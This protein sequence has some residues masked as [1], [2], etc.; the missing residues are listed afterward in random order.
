LVRPFPRI[1]N[2]LLRFIR[3]GIQ[4][5]PFKKNKRKVGF[6]SQYTWTRFKAEAIANIRLWLHSLASQRG[7]SICN[8]TDTDAIRPPASPYIMATRRLVG[9]PYQDKDPEKTPPPTADLALAAYSSRP[10]P[11]RALAMVRA[12]PPSFPLW[13][14]PNAGLID[15]LC[16]CSQTVK[17][18]NGGRSKHGRGQVKMVRCHNCAKAVPKVSSIIRPTFQIHFLVQ[19]CV[20]TVVGFLCWFR[21]RRSNATG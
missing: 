7:T 19:N 12:D 18:R 8:P 3:Y 2:V 9:K 10:R 13:M 21:T 16:R 15:P 17:R 1:C 4:C 14:R 6:L 20:S 5:V 11:R